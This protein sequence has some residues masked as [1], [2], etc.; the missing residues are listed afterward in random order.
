V[1]TNNPAGSHRVE[2]G[3]L[4]VVIALADAAYMGCAAL[5]L[6]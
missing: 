6:V 1:A 5:V 3:D 4:D 2:E